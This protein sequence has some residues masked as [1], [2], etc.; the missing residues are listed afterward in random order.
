MKYKLIIGIP[1]YNRGKLAFEGVKEI[2]DKIPKGVHIIVSDNGSTESSEYYEKISQLSKSNPQKLTY[3]KNSS[4]IGFVGNIIKLIEISN[5][6]WLIFCSDEDV[7]NIDY[8]EEILLTRV[9][10]TPIGIIRGS[11]APKGSYRGNSINYPDL[12]FERGFNAIKNFGMHNNYL[13]GIAYNLHLLR[14]KGIFEKWRAGIWAHSDYPHLYLD[15]LVC[16]YCDVKIS[17]MV[18][19]W[20]G[21]PDPGEDQAGTIKYKAP[22]SLGSRL[23][24][25]WGTQSAIFEALDLMPDEA[26]PENYFE[27]Y[28]LICKKYLHLVVNVDASIYARNNLEIKQVIESLGSFMKASIPKNFGYEGYVKFSWSIEKLIAGHIEKILP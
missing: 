10:E 25:F 22:Y 1:S 21:T 4:N 11:I 24:Q 16:A 28:I 2:I 5:S 6:D 9:D 12:S 27:M 18:S 23:D 14:V 17:S 8:V 26:K 19:C 13:S 3:Q 7:I 15:A 20:E